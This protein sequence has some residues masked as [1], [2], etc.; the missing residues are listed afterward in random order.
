MAGGLGWERHIA[1]AK[2]TAN[3]NRPTSGV[4]GLFRLQWS[5]TPIHAIPERLLRP[6]LAIHNTSS[7]SAMI[8]RS[9]RW[10]WW[11]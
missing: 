7:S 11:W 10:L 6:A 4:G 3:S 1:A 5:N 8:T 9:Q 2:A